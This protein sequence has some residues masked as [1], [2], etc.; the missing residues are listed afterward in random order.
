MGSMSL[1]AAANISDIVGGTSGTDVTD[2]VIG[3]AFAF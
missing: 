2:K 3:L 1:T